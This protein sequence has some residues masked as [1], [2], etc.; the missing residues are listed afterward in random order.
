MCACVHRHRGVRHTESDCSYT[1]KSCTHVPRMISA[2]LPYHQGES[3]DRCRRA[4]SRMLSCMVVHGRAGIHRT[5]ADNTPLWV[6]HARGACKH[7]NRQLYRS[8]HNAS[9]RSRCRAPTP[10][11]CPVFL[12]L[13]LSSLLLLLSVVVSRYKS[14]YAHYCHHVAGIVN[15]A[16]KKQARL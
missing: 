9:P 13:L 7:V 6:M 11:F 1:V 15:Q 10:A 8:E 4:W 12:L 3:A 5:S 16:S 2:T 14:R